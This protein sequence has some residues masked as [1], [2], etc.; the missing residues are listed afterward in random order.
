M[1]LTTRDSFLGL[2]GATFHVPVT[3]LQALQA[4]IKGL[5]EQMIRLSGLSLRD[6]RNING[7][8]EIVCTGLRPGEKLYEELLIGGNPI[9]T[10][11]PRIKKA[12]ES[13]MPWEQ[14]DGELKTLEIALNVNDVGVV[15]SLMVK[16][17]PD[18][19]PNSAIV[20]WVYAEGK[21]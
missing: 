2:G 7:D 20:D 5:A 1:S 21:S 10:S 13:F 9:E 18:Y 14:L 16:L 3:L 15:R 11:H 17:V 6:A 4:F 8:I 19:K 12:Q